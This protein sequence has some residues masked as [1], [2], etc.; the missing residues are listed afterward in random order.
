MSRLEEKR[1]DLMDIGRYGFY[2]RWVEEE[3]SPVEKFK[4]WVGLALFALSQA[5][6]VYYSSLSLD[7]RME[8][9]KNIFQ[10]ER[11]N[12]VDLQI[13][14]DAEKVLAALSKKYGKDSKA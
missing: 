13:K 10:R 12:W 3:M 1:V 11:R 14:I 5:R 2:S 6:R 8:L 9:G 4:M 7:E